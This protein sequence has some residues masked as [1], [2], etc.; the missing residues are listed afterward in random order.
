M[1]AGG[2]GGALVRMASFGLGS[3]LAGVLVAGVVDLDLETHNVGMSD[4][5]PQA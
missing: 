3:A 2:R 4:R 5:T 1:E